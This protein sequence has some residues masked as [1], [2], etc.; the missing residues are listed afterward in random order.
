MQCN[1]R[2]AASFLVMDYPDF[3][4]VHYTESR[5]FSEIGTT[6]Y[7]SLQRTSSVSLFLPSPLKAIADLLLPRRNDDD[8][9]NPQS[10]NS[11]FYG[12]KMTFAVVSCA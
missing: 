1:R 7:V 3:A 11:I 6:R 4:H 9:E 8:L 2:E 5:L 10:V 12:I